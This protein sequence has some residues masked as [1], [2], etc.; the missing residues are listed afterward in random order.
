[1]KILRNT[2][3]YLLSILCLTACYD[4]MDN[5][6]VL[7]T[8]DDAPILITTAIT[9]SVVDASDSELTNYQLSVSSEVKNI[10]GR[11]FLVQLEEVNKKGQAIY[12]KEGDQIN[13]MLHTQLIENDI[14][15]VKLQIF[16]PMNSSL[17]SSSGLDVVNIS[18]SISLQISQAMIK[19]TQGNIPTADVYI[20][21][22]DLSNLNNISQLG[23]SAYSLKNELRSTNHL[24]AFHL[25]LRGADGT[26]YNI[27]NQID[28]DISIEASDE[29]VSL[30]HFDTDDEKWKEVVELN[31]GGNTIQI[32]KTGLYT[33]S[34]HSKAI[35]AEGDVNK[36]GTKVSY[37]LMSVIQHQI[38]TSA[39]GR[40]ITI[41][42]SDQDISIS[43]LT[44]CQYE[45]ST[46]SLPAT[47]IDVNNVDL[48]VS[49]GNY[50]KLQTTVYDCN[51]ELEETT[52][53]YL[54]NKNGVGNIY[55]FS[56]KNIDAWVSVCNP[57]F[58]I[59]TYDIDTD[60]KGIS[61]PWSLDIVDDQSFLV[62]CEGFEDGYSYIKIQDD[63]LVLEPFDALKIV[64]D[65]IPKT[66]L[67]S[68]DSNIRFKFEGQMADNYTQ[69]EV[70]VYLNDPMFGDE[71]YFISCESSD[72]GCGFTTWNVTHY[73]AGNE[74][75]VRVS[76]AGEVW[77]QTIEPPQAGYFPVEGVI[78]TKA[79]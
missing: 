54:R 48:E 65:G 31:N 22:R 77:M 36:E 32:A 68:I 53:I 33:I 44:P 3:I 19:D 16:D 55:T 18:P 43:T 46:F 66:T 15:L 38:Y 30:F 1:M 52:A 50:Y 45:I 73:E 64:E 21:H 12:V 72:E 40:W 41:L 6:I 59:A 28:I 70:N 37:Q 62:S 56:D 35:Y 11:R 61:I 60:V 74:N 78:L 69:D 7:D 8:Q 4:N 75:W 9:G 63:R 10:E 29:Q 42:P 67:E 27:Q 20:D 5:S 47:S 39:E 49:D 14:N 13:S 71:G 23:V 24:S 57:E 76:F 58:D 2:S 79:Q 25:E 17:I 34:Q 26:A 51:G